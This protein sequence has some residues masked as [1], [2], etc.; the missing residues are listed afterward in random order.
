MDV[1]TILV[2]EGTSADLAAHGRILDTIPGARTRLAADPAIAMTAFVEHKTDLL[3]VV[4]TI[5][6]GAL[7][8]L[9]DAH[10]RSGRRDTPVIMITANGDKDARRAAYEYGVYNC[11]E[12]PIDPASYLCIARNAL[13]MQVMRRNE[14]TGMAAFQEQYKALE[15]QMEDKE[16]QVI[17]SLLH[18]ANLVDP[19]LSRR[20]ARVAAMAERIAHRIVSHEDARRFGIA[21]RVYDIGMLALT[22]Q[23]RERRAELGGPD[24]GRVLGPHAERAT[25][26]FGKE[27]V[28]LLDIASKVAR[29]HHERFDGRGYPDGLSGGEISIYAQIV[30]IAEAFI[31][32]TAGG[33][34]GAARTQPLTENQALAYIDRQTGTAFDPEAVEGLRLV[35]E[36]PLGEEPAT[37][38][39]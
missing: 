10:L 3:V 22:P 28:G 9:K 21:A 7:A 16:V 25:E 20:M 29:S 8:W 15:A 32:V 17:Y 1:M 34:P 4:D 12:K 13:S 33:V 24:A 18:A 35:I 27:P 37:L 39:G 2:L 30:A 31:D 6:G 38:K 36:S 14:A 5:D 19:L 23:H 26:I 11:I